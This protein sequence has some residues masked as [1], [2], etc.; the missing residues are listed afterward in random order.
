M[1]SWKASTWP[2]LKVS[3]IRKASSSGVPS[4]RTSSA[5]LRSVRDALTVLPGNSLAPPVAM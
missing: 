2:S 3:A 1:F 5:V 4:G